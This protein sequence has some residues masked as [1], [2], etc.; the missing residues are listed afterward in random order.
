MST[1]DA[2]DE[3]QSDVE[4][5]PFT[6]E[7]NVYAVAFTKAQGFVPFAI[8]VNVAGESDATLAS[9]VLGAPGRGPSVHP[10]IVA[11]PAE[12]VVGEPP[13]SVPEPSPIEKVTTTPGTGTPT[14]ST[15]FTDGFTVTAAPAFAV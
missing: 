14:E 6:V 7:P 9:K 5:V 13:F 2:S 8:A 10:P 3:G 12:L 15:T 1:Y 4:S 11:T